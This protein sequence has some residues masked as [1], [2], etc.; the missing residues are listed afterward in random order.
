MPPRAV[1]D[2]VEHKL[3]GPERVEGLQH[4]GSRHGA[5]EALPHGFVGEV[6]R[7]LFEA[8]KHAADGGAECDRNA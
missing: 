7:Q 6:V 5:Y 3:P 1:L 2:L 8:E 4:D